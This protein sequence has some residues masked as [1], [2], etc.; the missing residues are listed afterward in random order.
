M[1]LAVL[2]FQNNRNLAYVS[3]F[4]RFFYPPVSMVVVPRYYNSS[5][6]DQPE[7]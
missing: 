3:P 2:Q 5:P 7:C 4:V 1:W 6:E